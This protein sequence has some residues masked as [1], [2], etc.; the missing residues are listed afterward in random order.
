M[1][2]EEK[3]EEMNISAIFIFGGVKLI[4]VNKQV[5]HSLD[6]MNSI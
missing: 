4:Y 1:E 5:T 6:N 2:E 3:E